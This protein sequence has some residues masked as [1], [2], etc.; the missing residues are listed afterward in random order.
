MML[1]SVTAKSGVSRPTSICSMMALRL[2][3]WYSMVFD[4]HH[5]RRAPRVHQVD[6]RR[7]RGTLA[8]ARRT[9][10]QHQ[11]LPPLRQLRQ[12]QRQ[13]Q[14]FERRNPRRQQPY[15]GRQRPALVM[16]VHPEAPQVLA[17]EAQIHRLLL[18]QFLELPGFEQRQ[19]Q[20]AHILGVEQARAAGHQ[21][22]VDPVR[23]RPRS[24]REA[25]RQQRG[26]NRRRR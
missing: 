26:A 12:R 10:H 6:Q 2:A 20:A 4:G 1:R 21:H 9:G 23:E 3:C 8:A 17:H 16:D 22:A 15:A 14:R 18:V 25:L 13:M 7:Q 11:P 24:E 19:H 5:V